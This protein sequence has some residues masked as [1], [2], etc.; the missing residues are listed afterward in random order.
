MALDTDH[1]YTG[2]FY[3]N[4]KLPTMEDKLEAQRRQT[5]E[6]S[7]GPSTPSSPST[8]NEYPPPGRLP[9]GTGPRN[10]F[11]PS[12]FWEIHSLDLGAPIGVE[13]GPL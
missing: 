11:L 1:Y 9:G 2:V 7:P 6:S 12:V 13:S 4:D 3:R 10:L 5:M 8:N